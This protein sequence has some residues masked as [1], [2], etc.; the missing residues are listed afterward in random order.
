MSRK[1]HSGKPASAFAEAGF[2]QALA[3]ATQEIADLYAADGIPWVIG[4]SGGKDSTAALQ[5]VWQ[6]LEK[7]PTERRTKPVYVIST[8]TQVENPIV[9][10]WVSKSL[11]KMS[12]EAERQGELIGHRSRDLVLDRKDVREFTVICLGPQME[13]VLSADELCRD[14]EL[15]AGT[16]HAP[17]QHVIHAERRADIAQVFVLSF[18]RKA[19]STS[20]NFE[21]RDSYQRVQDLFGDAVGEVILVAFL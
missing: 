16:A 19:R 1:H 21:T 3:A 14:P 11:E 4:Y 5:L 9:A 6:A 13:A 7:V 12:T 20:G 15:V 18:V 8:D 17:L 10:L 2:Q